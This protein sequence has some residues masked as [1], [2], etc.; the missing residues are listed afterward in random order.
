MIAYPIGTLISACILLCI[1]LK[2]V[3]F[4]HYSKKVHHKNYFDALIKYFKS[5][6]VSKDLIDLKRSYGIFRVAFSFILP[7]IVVIFIFEIFK[8]FGIV[9][10]SRDVF[11]SLMLGLVSISVY[12]TLIEFDRWEYYAIFPLKKSDAIKSKLKTSFIIS[13]PLLLISISLMTKPSL[14][15]FLIGIVSMLYIIS[16]LVYLIDLEVSL[17]F[18]T[19]RIFIFS[20]F[21]APYFI[22]VLLTPNVLLILLTFFLISLLLIKFGL[23]KFD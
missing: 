8:L 23:E 3:D 2:T 11:Y 7:L 20:L 1:S 22:G 5:P 12:A 17:F 16:L 13:L 6:L 14:E 21:F 9:T 19:R 15:N 4:E 18:D 10:I